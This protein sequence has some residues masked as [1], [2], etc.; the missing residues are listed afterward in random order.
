M[1][2]I[3]DDECRTPVISL[4]EPVTR[5]Q[6]DSCIKAMFSFVNGTLRDRFDWCSDRIRYFEAVI[7]Y[8]HATQSGYDLIIDSAPDGSDFSALLREARGKILW[9]AN[10][11]TISMETAS[12]IF[13]ACGLPPYVQKK[14]A[15]IRVSVELHT[16]NISIAAGDYDTA[17]RWVI[18][19][20][21][22]FMARMLDG[23]PA[24]D[25]DKY[26]P[27]SVVMSAGNRPY[28]HIFTNGSQ[29]PVDEAD[30]VRP[31]YV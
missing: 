28:V 30:T 2:D 15:S 19:N 13:A 9:Y 8:S 16:F 22:D 21:Q 1:S 20:F 18:D 29:R 6:Y 31:S 17:R 11:T 4:D 23:K 27:G 7:P 25:G 5:E 3:Q 26:V 24:Q 12:E 10:A 14:E